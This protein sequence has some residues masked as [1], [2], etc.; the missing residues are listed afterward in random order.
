MPDWKQR[1]EW[2]LAFASRPSRPGTIS[3]R[4]SRRFASWWQDASSVGQGEIPET[5]VEGGPSLGPPSVPFGLPRAAG[6]SR[7][8]PAR[9]R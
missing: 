8:P 6:Q 1:M 3:V 4:P 7:Y 9:A 2:D 5:F